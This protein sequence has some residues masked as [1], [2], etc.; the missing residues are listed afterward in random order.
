MRGRASDPKRECGPRPEQV[1]ALQWSAHDKELVSSHGYS[2]NQLILWKYPSMVR[3]LGLALAQVRASLGLGF[4][5]TLTL[6]L[7]CEMVRV[8]ALAPTRT[9]RSLS[10][11]LTLTLSLSR[12]A[13]PS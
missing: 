9:L 10:L 6:N 4:G 1:C 2:H 13:S 11:T 5:W 12:C 8:A 7:T 3:W